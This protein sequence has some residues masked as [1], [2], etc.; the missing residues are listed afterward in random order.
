M[1]V[2]L[3]GGGSSGGN[4]DSCGSECR[5]GCGGLVVTSVGVAT[6]NEILSSQW[7]SGEV[8]LSR[9]TFGEVFFDGGLLDEVTSFTVDFW[10]SVSWMVDFLAK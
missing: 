8:F 3:D 9:W 4:Q 1:L 2:L 5:E 7:T 6:S 10:Q